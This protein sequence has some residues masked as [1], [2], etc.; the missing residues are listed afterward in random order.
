MKWRSK[1]NCALGH[2][3]KSDGSFG[4]CGDT[5]TR[6]VSTTLGGEADLLFLAQAGE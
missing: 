1:W 3:Y 6:T 4:A 5:V 2:G